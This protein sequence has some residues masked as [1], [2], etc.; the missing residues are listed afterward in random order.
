MNV[1]VLI[2]LK[3]LLDFGL[4]LSTLAVSISWAVTQPILIEGDYD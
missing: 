3:V 1:H 4:T 2:L